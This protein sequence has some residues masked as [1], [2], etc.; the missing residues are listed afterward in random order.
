MSGT[1]EVNDSA[2]QVLGDETQRLIARELADR[3]RRN[4]TIDWVD[5]KNARAKMR[6]T[7]KRLLRQ[8]GYPPDK[9]AKAIETVL[10][11]AKVL[12]ASWVT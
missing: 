10:D 1:L 6:I 7:V 11:Q 12:E 2:S 4:S 9:Q 8:C 3:V 5:P